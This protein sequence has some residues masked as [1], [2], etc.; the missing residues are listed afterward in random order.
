MGLTVTERQQGAFEHEALLY[1]DD[2]DYVAGVV[3]FLRDAVAAGEPALVVVNADK[4]ELLRSSLNGDADAVHFADMADV[5][6][7][8][9]RIIPAWRAFAEEQASSGRRFRGIGE[10]VWAARSSDELV[11]CARHEA[12]LNL[13]F[14]GPPAGGLGCPD[15]QWLL[16]KL[17]W[18]RKWRW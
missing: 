11:E 18:R 16:N 13:A 17:R 1:A 5:G 4:I 2:A 14:A 8:P 7:N 15:D 9:A 12:L 3:P 10:P 6:A